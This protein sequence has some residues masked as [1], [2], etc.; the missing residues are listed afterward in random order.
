MTNKELI[1]ALRGTQF[2]LLDEAA[3]RIL[4]YAIE[5]SCPIPDKYLAKCGGTRE[6][7]DECRTCWEKYLDEEEK[8]GD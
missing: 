6:T 8:D 1:L 3:E 7:L 5:Y 4:G 2:A